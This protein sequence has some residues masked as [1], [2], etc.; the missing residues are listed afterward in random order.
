MDL[1]TQAVLNTS[2]LHLQDAGEEPMYAAGADGNP[3]MQKPVQVVMYSPGTK[4]FANASAR[5]SNRNVQRMVRGKKTDL[6]AD[7]QRRESAEFLADTTHSFEN[8]TYGDKLPTTRD[9]FIA[10]YSDIEIG[11]IAEQAAKFG[12]DWAN[13]KKKPTK[14]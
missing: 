1:K 5:R 12:S 3:D 8:L 14:S 11:F 7:E 2:T 9:E 6:S 10:V 4:Q 13:F